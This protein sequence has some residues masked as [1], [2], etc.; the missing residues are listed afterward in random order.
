M[1]IEFRIESQDLLMD[2]LFSH[3]VIGQ[4][5]GSRKTGNYLH[6]SVDTVSFAGF[7]YGT[8][9]GHWGKQSVQLV[10]RLD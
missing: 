7:G 3:I 6:S 9:V 8:Y 2:F 10:D 1:M 4:K 5:Q